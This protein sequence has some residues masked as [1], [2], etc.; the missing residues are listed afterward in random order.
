MVVGQKYT[1]GS[2]AWTTTDKKTVSVAGKTGIA[3][4]KKAGAAT[5]TNTDSDITKTYAITVHSPA[6]S[7][8][9]TTLNVG[10]TAEISIS[11]TG[12]MPVTW[13]SSN[14]AVFTVAASSDNKEAAVITAIG[15]GSAKLTAYVGG[16]KYSSTVVVKAA[17]SGL[18]KSD[19]YLNA[20]QTITL[21]HAG[22]T[23]KNLTGWTIEDESGIVTLINA[24]KPAVM[25]KTSAVTGTDL[26]RDITLNCVTT[27]GTLTT[28]L[29]LEDPALT[30]DTSDKTTS[31]YGK[32]AQP[33]AV[34][35]NY[36]LKLKAGDTYSISQPDVSQ[37]VIWTSSASSKAFAD[38]YGT[39]TARAAG[40][41]TL[42]A[43]INNK[44]VKIVVTV[45]E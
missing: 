30:I 10:D 33:K 12:S 37:K 2:G 23:S 6:L 27:A 28:I 20:G 4:A 14:N 36:T 39:I 34:A 26:P 9:K 16:K 43:K 21:K 31:E 18:V 44:T 22:V 24:D 45:T 42:T 1:F 13:T 35:L 3:T 19:I 41:S 8:K 7:T 5:I 29:H 38:E 32:L 17:S 15:T 40:K 25:I 11:D